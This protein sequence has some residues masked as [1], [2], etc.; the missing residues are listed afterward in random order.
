MKDATKFTWF[1]SFTDVLLAMEDDYTVEEIHAFFKAVVLYGTYGVEPEFD[2]RGLRSEFRGV[3]ADIDH[4]INARTNNK[5]G[6]PPKK[7][8]GKTGVSEVSETDNGGYAVENLEKPTVTPPTEIHIQ[9]NTDAK[10]EKKK[11]IKKKR[12]EP[13]TVD[14]VRTYV[15]EKGYAFDADAFVAH[16]ESNGWKV[17]KNPMKD[18]RAACRT[19]SRN[20][21]GRSSPLKAA[22]RYEAVPDDPDAWLP[23]V[24][25]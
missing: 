18:W 7:T 24:I 3:K 9:S 15:S 14:E 2:D 13:P 22:G 10:Q 8:A 6:R 20:D 17:G 11:Y 5:G 12:F 25:S 19:W 4:S 23:E 1:Q 16:Y 21:Y